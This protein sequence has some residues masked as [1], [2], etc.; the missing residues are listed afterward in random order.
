MPD[1]SVVDT[2]AS[3][4][5]PIEVPVAQKRQDSGV[6]LATVWPGPHVVQVRRPMI[7]EKPPSFSLS[8]VE[9]FE[10]SEKTQIEED[11]LKRVIADQE[12]EMEWWRAHP[13]FRRKEAIGEEGKLIGWRRAVAAAEE[14]CDRNSKKRRMDAEKEEQE[15]EEDRRKKG[16]TRIMRK[17]G[18]RGSGGGSG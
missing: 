8:L 10:L 11:E 16:K 1:L 17:E 15:A 14:E 18:G 5:P 6:S 9:L 2:P 7:D 12:K 13:A 4:S 3:G